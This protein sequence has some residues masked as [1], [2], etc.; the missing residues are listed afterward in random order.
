MQEPQETAPR[1]IPEPILI[2]YTAKKVENR[3]DW[4]KDAGVEEICSVSNCVSGGLSKAAF[5]RWLHNG[6]CLYDR[7]STVK[8]LLGE[9]ADS[10]AFSLF[11]LKLL[12]ITFADSGE[13]PVTPDHLPDRAGPIPN[14]E[15]LPPGYD[16]LGYDCVQTEWDLSVAGFGCSPLSCNGM[17]LEL[18]VN[19]HCLID[20]LNDAIAAA[21][22][23]AREQPE[24]GDYYV[25]EV[26]RKRRGD[27][28]P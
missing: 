7:E 2:G 26:W 24:P 1:P 28:N 17:A 15:P 4:L 3:P 20:R 6:L 5:E 22:T 27:A 13:R 19:R 9:E 10:Q 16:K 11:A 8:A 21:R 18:A 23:F 12:P 25:V 14:A